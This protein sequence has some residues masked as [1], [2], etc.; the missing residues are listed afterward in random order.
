MTDTRVGHRV[1]ANVYMPRRD[2]ATS[3]DVAA[4]AEAARRTWRDGPDIF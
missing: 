1:F 2:R 4:L 3:G